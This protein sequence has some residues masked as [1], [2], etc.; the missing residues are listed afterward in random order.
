MT[1]Q[2]ERPPTAEFSDAPGGIP[3]GGTAGQ[4]LVKASD[5]DYDTE[6]G[7]SGGD[8][9]ALTGLADDDHPQYVLADGSRDVTGDLTVD[10][11]LDVSGGLDVT[12]VV[13]LYNDVEL[14]GDLDVSKAD[15]VWTLG[16][17]AEIGNPTVGTVLLQ[18]ARFLVSRANAGEPAVA[19]Q[20]D[21]DAWE[22]WT[23]TRE[24]RMRWGDG[25]AYPNLAA[26]ELE[27]PILYVQGERVILSGLDGPGGEEAIAL[28]L[29][30][31]ASKIELGAN[32]VEV[33]SGTLSAPAEKTNPVAASGAAEQLKWGHVNDV[34]MDENCALSFEAVGNTGLDACWSLTLILRGAFV[35]SWPAS[36]QWPGGV[37]PTY[38]SPSVYTFMTVDDGVTILG[39]QAG[40][41]MAAP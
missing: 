32:E 40:A 9:G 23:V 11:D 41:G 5:D 8:H 3:D 37:E 34:T 13:N 25:T 20:A 27:D 31:P 16:N 14:G 30:G 22:R 2:R 39:F 35:P 29:N 10:A 4:A 6:W 26:I 18:W 7:S 38:T 12:G 17:G 33:D 21:G 24:G 15:A 1:G 19:V 36:V 28:T